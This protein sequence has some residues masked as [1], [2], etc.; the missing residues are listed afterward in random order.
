MG[1]ANSNEQPLD[2]KRKLKHSASV[3]NLSKKHTHIYENKCN[4]LSNCDSIRRQKKSS[5]TSNLAHVNPRD[6]ENV[7]KQ[8]LTPN[9]NAE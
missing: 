1:N 9:G 6:Y 7:F 2:S 3:S 8:P 5:S 4:N